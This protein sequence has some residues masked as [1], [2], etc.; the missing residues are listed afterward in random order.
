MDQTAKQKM[1]VNGYKLTL[2][3]GHPLPMGASRQNCGYNFSIFSKNATSVSIVF[4]K[5]GES[6]PAFE[7]ELDPDQ[8]RCG[9]IWHICINGLFEDFRYGYRLDGPFDQENGHH[10]DKKNILVEPYARALTGGAV[11]GSPLV[12]SE[13]HNFRYLRRAFLPEEDFDWQG[14]RP[15]NRPLK[16]SIIYELH[17][18][19]YTVSPTSGV[20]NP[21][22]F[23]GLTEKIPYLKELGITAVE[24]MP[25]HEFDEEGNFFSNPDTGERLK[26]Y[27]GYNPFA[28]FAPKASYAATALD[29]RQVEEF[30]EM[31]REL[32]KAGIEVILDVVFNHTGEGGDG[33]PAFSFRGFEN[34]VYYM[35]NEHGQN[36]NYSG[37]GNT[38]NCNH[39]VVRTLIIDC[40]RYWVTEMHVDGFR[41]DLASVLG[42]DQKGNVLQNPPVLEEIAN[43]PILADTKI[44]AEAWDAAGLYQVGSFPA[45]GR[46]AEWN[47]RFRDDLRHYLK[48]DPECVSNMATRVAGSSDL[49]HSSGRHPYHSINFITSHDGFTLNDLVTYNEK[50]NLANGEDSRDGDNNNLSWNCGEEGLTDNPSV[51]R[52]RARQVRNAIVMLMFSQGTPMITAGDEFL[53]TQQGNNNAYCQDNEISWVDWTLAEKNMDFLRFCKML[54][55]FRKK[56]HVLRRD[57]F[58]TGT[59]TTGDG[60]E[61]ISWHG[62]KQGEPDFSEESRVIGILID[63]EQTECGGPDSEIFIACNTGYKPSRMQIP[64]LPKI[65]RG[66]QWY[67]KID[68]AAPAPG[69][70]LEEGR[71]TR[72]P[73][74]W[75]FLRPRSI[76]VLITK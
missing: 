22:T 57:Y 19:G 47:G 37:C 20:K 39:P 21:G 67:L 18:R 23:R 45:W 50:H 33:G 69:D 5:T 61:D 6:D 26:K 8:N 53:R 15:L 13:G 70:F 11:W 52:L 38:V 9:E 51:R 1:E 73:P 60:L 29:G 59:D 12:R 10:F 14:D 3:P 2:S 76:K 4:F 71:E 31:V 43:D 35:I 63:G 42:R 30:K 55:A 66:K 32:H 34:S 27:W 56:H 24:L 74:D 25:V 40:L 36:M 64:P 68:T 62:I 44:I 16:D 49:Y 17:L 54:I 72:M 28:F 46:W 58:F 65:N 7:I 75:M 41:F 48:G